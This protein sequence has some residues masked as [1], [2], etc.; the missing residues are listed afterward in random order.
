MFYLNILLE[1]RELNSKNI[2]KMK[3]MMNISVQRSETITSTTT[4]KKK[5][6]N[7]T[8][9]I[10]IKISRIQLNLHSIFFI[11]F[12]LFLFAKVQY[13]SCCALSCFSQSTAAFVFS[14]SNLHL[15][16][17]NLQPSRSF[18]HHYTLTPYKYTLVFHEQTKIYTRASGEIQQLRLFVSDCFSCMVSC[19]KQNHHRSKRH[20]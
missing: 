5:K 16:T 15:P 19:R 17:F 12:Y 10:N 9:T 11:L 6:N 8:T 1:L 20:L 18:R 7:T 2:I 4:K 14:N 13:V 3:I